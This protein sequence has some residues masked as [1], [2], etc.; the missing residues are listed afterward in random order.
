MDVF[1]VD[2]LPTGNFQ[3]ENIPKD[4]YVT[5]DWVS[6][7]NV[8]TNKVSTYVP[9]DKN[10]TD[11]VLIGNVLTDNNIKLIMLPQLNW[12]SRWNCNG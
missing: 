3:T 2:N 7:D 10:S 11:I 5:R 12:S 1:L 9:T 6:T 8:S 4:N